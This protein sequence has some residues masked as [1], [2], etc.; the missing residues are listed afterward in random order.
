MKEVVWEEKHGQAKVVL[1]MLVSDQRRRYY[2]I[3]VPYVYSTFSTYQMVRNKECL[4]K[5]IRVRP[6]RRMMEAAKVTGLESLM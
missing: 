2:L 1:A 4:L 6:L 3:N 5:A